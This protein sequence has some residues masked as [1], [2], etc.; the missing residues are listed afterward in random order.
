VVGPGGL[1]Q[2]AINFPESLLNLLPND[3][4]VDVTKLVAIS[5]PSLYELLPFNDPRWECVAA[6]GTRRRV[7]AQELLT[8]GP[9]QPY[10]PT[11]ELERRLYIDD[12]LRKR[13]AEGRKAIDL[14]D[15]EFCQDPDLRALQHILAQVREW[16]LRMGELGYTNT[17][18]TTPGQP[19]R[20]HVVVSNG[21]K[22]PTGIITEGAHDSSSS[23]YTYEDGIDGDGTVTTV[24]ALDDLPP[25]APNVKML[26]GVSHG[27]LMSDE[28]FLDYLYG[29]LS[30]EP[31]APPDR[32]SAT[33]QTL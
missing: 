2:N 15:W 9:W 31:M 13:M 1:K 26:K 17:L 14:P 24:S 3:V 28:Q 4:D 30:S 33:N 19:S 6:D 32:R 12:W 10:W 23:R 11:A 20:L 16:R 25:T 8:I 21:L 7:S 18:L 22:T 5:R 27:K 29:E